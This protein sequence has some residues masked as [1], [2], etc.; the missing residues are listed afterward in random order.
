MAYYQLDS[1]P[2]LDSE[3]ESKISFSVCTWI[4]F[5]HHNVLTS[6]KYCMKNQSTITYLILIQ[7]VEE[8]A[9][10]ACKPS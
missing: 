3:N 2:L 5:P 10:K 1:R 6:S 9:E 7:S 8:N 4:R